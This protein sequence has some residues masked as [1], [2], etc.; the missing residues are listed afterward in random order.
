MPSRYSGVRAC[1]VV[2]LLALAPIPSRSQ[3]NPCDPSLSQLA[4]GPQGYRLR[5]NRCEGIYVQPVGSTTLL[6]ASFTEGFENFNPKSPDKLSVEWS[7]PGGNAIHLRAYGL[8]EK[9]Y[10]QMDAAVPP[11]KTSLLWDADLLDELHLSKE[12][13]GVVGFTDYRIGAENKTLY[14]PL[15]I[16]QTSKPK[17]ASAYQL[18]VLPGS[19]LKELFISLARVGNDGRPQSFLTSDK[20]LGRSYYP[21]ERGIPF[22]IPKPA[23]PGIYYLELGATSRYGGTATQQ[24]WFYNSGG[25]P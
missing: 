8:H 13:I 25:H 2:T 18:I 19:E 24:V 17:A 10:Y 5:G 7:S 11:N 23:E 3:Q 6:L 1:L 15:T 4:Q 22:E 14:L 21:A 20:P 12:D 16:R 9:L